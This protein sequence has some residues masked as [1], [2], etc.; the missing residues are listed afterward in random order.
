MGKYIKNYASKAAYDADETR[1][2]DS[3]VVSNIAGGRTIYDGKNVMLPKE[4][5][6]VGDMV[7]VEN[8]ELK[9]IKLDTYDATLTTL[10]PFGVVY[11]RW[12]NKVQILDKDDLGSHQYAAPFRAKIEGFDLMSGGSYIAKI[13]AAEYPFTVSAGA[14]LADASAAL[15]AALPPA[16]GWTAETKE[17]Y[18]VAQ[19]NFHTPAIDTF[20]VIGATCT[21][22][23]T[24]QQAR[25]TGFLKPYGNITRRNGYSH[26][27]GGGNFE[28][29]LA[30][31]EV[32]G[33][34]AK[35]VGIGEY[36]V[37]RRSVFNLNDNANLFTAY[38]SYEDY[39]LDNMAKLPYSKSAGSDSNGQLNTNLLAAE[40]YTDDD[41]V[42]KPQYPAAHRAQQVALGGLGWWLESAEE[43]G[44]LMIHAGSASTPVNI[45]RVAI[46]GVRISNTSYYWTSTEHSS[47]SAWFY[48]GRNGYILRSTKNYATTVRAVT[49]FYL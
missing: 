31:Y 16:L 26:L 13:N 12:G 33:S 38:A 44:V 11:N 43:C 2:I 29:F 39:I 46:G 14:T 15:L 42:E 28:R 19:R 17:G 41:G 40:M 48:N 5:V 30:Y 21:I 25:L 49:A 6:G 1:P 37:V 20:D 35:S 8:G 34:E 24:D 4:A 27:Y 47:S 45:S 36:S 9:F 32:N 10:R 18:I 22:L 7:A 23:N 3:S